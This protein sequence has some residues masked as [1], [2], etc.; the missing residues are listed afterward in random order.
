MQLL[1]GPPAPITSNETIPAESIFDKIP[2]Y[3]LGPTE[4]YFVLLGKE[5]RSGVT[6]FKE[7][8]CRLAVGNGPTERAFAIGLGYSVIGIMLALYLN[9]LTI[10]NA[11]SA[12]RAVRNAV[13]QQLLVIKVSNGFSG[14]S[15]PQCLFFV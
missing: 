10:G 7:G 4:P 6:R 8:W 12:T 11:R 2:A 14:E 5:V 15:V 3:Y 1:S 13:R 9:V